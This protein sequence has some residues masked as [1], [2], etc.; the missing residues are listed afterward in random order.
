MSGPLPIRRIQPI[1]SGVR[2]PERMFRLAGAVEAGYG[3]RAEPVSLSR[4]EDGQIYCH[5]GHHR[6]AACAVAGREELRE[7]EYALEDWTYAQYQEINW[8][9]NWTTP[10]DP[11]LETRAADLT[12][13]RTALAFVVERAGRAAAEAFIWRHTRLYKL[14]RVVTTFVE[15]VALCFDAGQWAAGRAAAQETLRILTDKGVSR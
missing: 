8:E 9:V 7:G 1:Q 15:L 6:V 13:F 14:P 10:F 2:D 5:N 4:F 3:F 12:P 11:R